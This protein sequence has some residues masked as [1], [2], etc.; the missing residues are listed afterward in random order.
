MARNRSDDAVFVIG[1]GRFGS[2]VADA[3]TRLGHDV[4][5]VDSSAEL[6]REWADRLTHVVEADATN[7]TT[8]RQLGAQHFNTAVVAIGTE[9]EASLLTTGVLADL[10]VPSIWAKAITVAHGRLLERVGAHHVV[11]PE[12]SMGERVAHLLSSRV[13]DFIEFDDGYA[14]VKMR[15]PLEAIDRTLGETGLR[16]KYGVTVV[17]IK[18]KGEDFTHAQADTEVRDG[19]LLIVSG[20]TD[21]VEKFAAES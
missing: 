13:L 3:L 6:V 12:R 7:E 16:R 19:D 11:Y 17:G 9:V 18:R 5:A 4:L 2:A 15:A 1:L 20:R 10:Q 14:I 8:L 21:L